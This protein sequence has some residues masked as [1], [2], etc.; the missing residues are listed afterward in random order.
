MSFLPVPSHFDPNKV[1][2]VWRVPYQARA[3]EA[4][5][6]AQRHA[7]QPATDDRFKIGLLLVD[8]QNTFCLPDFELFVGGRTGTGAMDDSRRICDFIYRN[9]HRISEIIVTMDTHQAIQIF[10]ANFLI[11]GKNEH[12]DPYTTVSVEDIEKDHW[13]F[14]PLLLDSFEMDAPTAERQLLHYTRSLKSRGKYLWTIWPYH[15]MLGG[16][17]HALV[18]SIE[19]A[20]FFHTIARYSQPHII[21]KGD[22]PLTEHYSVIGPEVTRD[23]SGHQIASRNHELIDKLMNLDALFIAGQAKSH[24]VAWTV[25]DLQADIQARGLSQGDT[26]LAE[27]VYLLE[28]CTSSVVIPGVVDYT[29]QADSA[30]QDFARMGMKIVHSDEWNLD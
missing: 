30:Y 3:A 12:P 7:I 5:L 11:N 16:I 18:S 28:D 4:R 8:V 14:N 22:N 6:W 25:E 24:C 15:A 29:E 26:T 10:H 2:E 9:L 19:E 27:K 21:T 17:G 23:A 1:N 13:K 20:I